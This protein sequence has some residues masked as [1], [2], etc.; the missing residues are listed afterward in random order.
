MKKLYVTMGSIPESSSETSGLLCF[1]LYYLI[2]EN[3]NWFRRLREERIDLGISYVGK[4]GSDDRR[5]PASG[6]CGTL[7]EFQSCRH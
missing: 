4:L 1:A 6:Y 5:N 3:E 7:Y 2:F